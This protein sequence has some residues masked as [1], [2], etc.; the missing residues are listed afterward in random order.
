MTRATRYR[1]EALAAAAAQALV[2]RLPRRLALA[3]GRTLGRLWGRLDVRHMRIARDNLGASFPDW[4][5]QRV[6]SVARGVYAHF[7][8]VIFDLLWMAG[9]TGSELV[10]LVDVEGDENVRAAAAP[11]RGMLYCTA[12]LGNWEVHGIAHALRYGPVSVVA[13]PL[14]N[15]ALDARL[16]ALRRVTG[17][18]VVYKRKALGSVLRELRA[19]RSAA[20]LLDQNV[21]E[22]DGIF[23]DFFGRKA[24]TTTVAAA[25]ALKTGCALLP[26]WTELQRNGRYRLRY[27]PAVEVRPEAERDAEIARITQELASRTESWIR[28]APEQWL[29]L[30][31]RWKTQPRP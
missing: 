13:R 18:A 17:N 26:A 9:R 10:S 8:A 23:V 1:L 7:G 20:M 5:A 31:R 11:G 24:A 14:E 30:H 4:S 15:P 22:E 21:L 25:L 28:R 16:V 12:H 19:G 29:W 3:A 2:R 27:E 6:R